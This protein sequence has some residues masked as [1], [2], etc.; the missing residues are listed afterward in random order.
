MTGPRTVP[1]PILAATSRAHRLEARARSLQGPGRTV[2]RN[3][4]LNAATQ[5]RSAIRKATRS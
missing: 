1:S 5:I 3:R 4:L 2:E